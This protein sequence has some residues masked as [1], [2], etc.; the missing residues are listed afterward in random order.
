[1]RH[2]QADVVLAPSLW[3]IHPDHVAVGRAVMLAL[4][5]ADPQPITG[6]FYEVGASQR[7]NLL[8]DVSAVWQRKANAMA[9]FASQQQRQDYARHIE[10][11]NAWRTY[12]LPV[13]VRYAEGLTTMTV[14]AVRQ[15]AGASSDPVAQFIQHAMRSA[16]ASADTAC[17]QLRQQLQGQSEAMAQREDVISGLQATV[18][19]QTALLRQQETRLMALDLEGKELLR[20][21]SDMQASTSW[22]VT[23][24]L[25]WISG[26]L[27]RLN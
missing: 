12:T 2:A 7:V 24:P 20:H 19:K 9:C 27:R 5:D 10:A 13:A 8:V 1:M 18:E 4:R 14:D 23:A 11:L 25:R 26:R 15:L 21:L 3:E 17:E 22:R 6:L 16:A